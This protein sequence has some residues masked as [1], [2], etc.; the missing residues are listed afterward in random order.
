MGEDVLVPVKV[1]MGDDPCDKELLSIKQIPSSCENEDVEVNVTGG[2]NVEKTFVVEASCEDATECSSSFGGTGSGEENG[3]SFTD[4]EVESRRFADDP[5]SSM[6]DNWFK[7]CQ[8]SIKSV[9]RSGRMHRNKVMKRNRRKKVE[10]QCDLASYMSNHSLFSYHEKKDCTV[11]T[12]L[13]DFRDV[14]LGVNDV[15]EE[16]KLNDMCSSTEYENHDKSLDDILQEIEAIQSQVRQLKTRT[17]ALQSKFHLGDLLMP[18]NASAS[19]EGITPF[20]EIT[21]SP[22]LHDP[23][24]DTKDGFLLHNRAAKEEGHVYKYGGNCLLKRTNESIQEDKFISK[25]LVSEPASPENVVHNEHSTRMSCSTLMP[26]IPTS[27]R[28]RRKKYGPS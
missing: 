18:G 25:I 15:N 6:C 13:K 12:C 21:N 9:P 23:W 22:E 3:Q 4:T 24:E 16:L 10:E 17:D 2:S 26:N 7:S 8:R 20:I 1:Y 19:L 11:D 27:K 28:K 14:G 5:S